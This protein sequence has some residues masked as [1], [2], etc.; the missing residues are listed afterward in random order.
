M[1]TEQKEKFA[2]KTSDEKQWLLI[3]MQ[4][5]ACAKL[6]GEKSDSEWA[7]AVEEVE[8]GTRKR[9]VLSPG[10]FQRV[11]MMLAAFALENLFKYQ[12]VRNNRHSILEETSR[13][14]KLPKMLNGHNLVQLAKQSGFQY[15]EEDEKLLKRLSVNSTWIGRY[16]I[17][18]NAIDYAKYG[19]ELFWSSIDTNEVKDLINKVIRS[20]DPDY[21]FLH[22]AP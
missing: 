21:S 16:P 9:E 3:A 20:I 12:L 7:R 18:T 5:M 2:K 13:T 17:P 14:S 22:R 1:T 10:N 4:L 8:S 6:I 15:N 11:H 19:I